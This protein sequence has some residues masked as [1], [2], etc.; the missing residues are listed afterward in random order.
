MRKLNRTR[1]DGPI[2]SVLFTLVITRPA[3]NCK[4]SFDFRCPVGFALSPPPPSWALPRPKIRPTVRCRPTAR[5]S[6]DSPI[7]GRQPDLSAD[8]RYLIRTP[9][10]TIGQ[11]W[12]H[13]PTIGLLGPWADRRPI[14][15]PRADHRPILGPWVDLYTL[16][17]HL[18]QMSSVGE[19]FDAPAPEQFLEAAKNVITPLLPQGWREWEVVQNASSKLNLDKNRLRFALPM[20][21]LVKLFLP[22]T[23]SISE[24]RFKML[25][26]HLLEW[27]FARCFI[28]HPSEYARSLRL[29]EEAY[30]KF[31]N[32]IRPLRRLTLS[33][34]EVNSFLKKEADSNSL[35]RTPVPE[36]PTSPPFEPLSPVQ[37]PNSQLEKRLTSLEAKISTLDSLSDKFESFTQSIVELIRPPPRPKAQESTDSYS[38]GSVSDEFSPSEPE[39]EHN[40]W[41]P[42]IPAPTPFNLPSFEPSTLESEPDIPPPPE[43]IS[44]S[45]KKCQHFGRDSWNR[46]LYKDAGKRLRH[47]GGFLPL[48]V[49]DQLL[50]RG[51]DDPE[52]RLAEGSIGIIQ[53]AVL[54]QREAFTQAK[55]ALFAA[56]PQ[57][58]PHFHQAFMSE[59]APFRSFSQDLVQYV[60]GKRSEIISR[61][62]NQF[63]PLDPGLRR[64]IAKIPPSD[65]HLFAED[66][67]SKCPLP[68]PTA[69]RRS[70]APPKR[71]PDLSLNF[72]ED[73]PTRAKQQKTTPRPSYKPSTSRKDDRRDPKLRPSGSSGKRPPKH[74]RKP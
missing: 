18:F 33:R 11:F 73:G 32:G 46:I 60:C 38:E 13:G 15:G 7:V 66:L 56:C 17:S 70:T 20:L 25:K 34:E 3:F 10:P 68:P 8:S 9:V 54:A 30:L 53:F 6:A 71:R 14:L 64:Q 59:T 27:P 42:E 31:S 12:G 43:R 4:K 28:S 67:L 19:L 36:S 69:P 35:P 50:S 65:S 21:E 51:R 72:R 52:L 49:N 45:L 41:A 63:L 37:G 26:S 57:A 24:P 1:T 61:R 44:D 47:G 2:L 5:L 16:P 23:S 58:I 48:G 62:R 40:L 22:G 74:Y 39:V 55:D 29:S